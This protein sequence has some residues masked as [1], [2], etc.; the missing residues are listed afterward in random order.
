MII[1]AEG[2]NNSLAGYFGCPNS[3]RDRSPFEASAKWKDIYLK[4]GMVFMLSGPFA[5][6]G[7]RRISLSPLTLRIATERFSALIEGYEWTV[8]DTYSAQM[9][10]PYETVGCA[11]SNASITVTDCRILSDCV[12]IQRFL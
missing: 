2:F 11:C 10:C 1:E 6:S 12:W 8:E 7:V 5:R 3:G 9:M 4:D